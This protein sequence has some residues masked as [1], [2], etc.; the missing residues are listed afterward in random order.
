MK[1]IHLSDLHIGKSVN[2]FSM[3]EDQKYIL[4]QI[5][6]II[7]D[8]DPKAVLIAGDVYNRLTPSTEAVKL[9]DDFLYKLSTRDLEVFLIS[10]NHDSSERLS[11]GRRMMKEN[12]HIAPTY[13][14]TVEPVRVPDEHGFV[15]IWMLPFVIPQNVRTMLGNKL[16]NDETKNDEAIKEVEAIKT[17]QDALKAIVKDMN[18][19]KKERNVLVMHQFITDAEQSDSEFNKMKVGTLENIDADVFKDFDYVALG[20]IHKPQDIANT[21]GRIRYCGTPLKYS[22]SEID[23]DKSVTVIELGSKAG[24]EGAEM[25][26]YFVPLK[27]L[28][29]M[30]EIR[31]T[32]EEIMSKEFYKEADYPSHYVKVVLSEEK[33]I[34]DV[35]TKLRKVYPYVMGYEYERETT[36]GETEDGRMVKFKDLTPLEL[37]KEFYLDQRGFEIKEEHLEV[38]KEIIDALSDDLDNDDEE[39]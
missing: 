30:K 10:G 33:D 13:D 36:E 3:I 16:A 9:L 1:F 15:N 31:G 19:D 38:V 18:I 8:E 4:E 32:F 39:V 34:P 14:G 22:F 29:D 2:G 35:M 23:R 24:E 25:E 20:H 7:D 21:A 17:F 28:R 12:V 5:L 6:G 11:F 37:F 27:P 26:R